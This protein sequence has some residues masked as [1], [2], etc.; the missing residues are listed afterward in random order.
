MENFGSYFIEP[1]GKIGQGGFGYVEKIKLYNS[2]M[3][4]CGTF[5]RKVFS[6]SSSV[7][8]QVSKDDLKRRFI[9]EAMYQ[10]KCTHKNVNYICLLNKHADNPYF[11]MDLA[12]CDLA[13]DITNCALTDLQKIEVVK[14]ISQGIL[15]IHNKGFLHRDLKPQNILR[16]PSGAYAISDFGLVK[17]T[18]SA[19]NTTAL[20]AIGQAMG[21]PRYMAPEILYNAE[22]SIKTDIFS[23]GK[24]AEDLNIQDDDFRQLIAGCSSM[25]EKQR[26]DSIDAFIQDVASLQVQRGVRHA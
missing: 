22:Y 25:D 12:V 4:P 5:A 14:M 1:L 8:A 23:L 13:S 15:R 7:L 9:R 26:Y 11:V 10:S 2:T 19:A 20:T 18:D 21:T 17:N 3:S 24:V 16:M 6:P